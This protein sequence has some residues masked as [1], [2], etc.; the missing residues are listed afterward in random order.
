M[1]VLSSNNIILNEELGR[2]YK[3]TE[4][5]KRKNFDEIGHLDRNGECY[6]HLCA[7]LLSVLDEFVVSW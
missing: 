5:I 1:A 7:L 6:R 4:L 2:H 3:S